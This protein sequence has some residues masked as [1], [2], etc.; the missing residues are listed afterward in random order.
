MPNLQLGMGLYLAS[1]LVNHSCEPNMYQV[2]YGTSVVF[3]AKR[4]IGKGEQLTCCYMEP[5]LPAVLFDRQQRQK[6]LMDIHKFQC[7]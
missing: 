7:R 3:R 1:S 6:I 2:F 4:P 5:A